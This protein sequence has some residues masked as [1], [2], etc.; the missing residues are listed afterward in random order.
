MVRRNFSREAE[1][2]WLRLRSEINTLARIYG[3]RAI[4]ARG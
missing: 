3:L 1:N 4:G 2:S